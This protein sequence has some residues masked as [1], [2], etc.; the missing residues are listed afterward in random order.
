[1]GKNRESAYKHK[2]DEW[3]QL[4]ESG[5]S[6]TSIAKKEGVF[7]RTV[8]GVLKGVV[9]PRPKQTYAHMVD[10]WVRDYVEKEMNATEIAEA[11]G[12]DAVTVLKYLKSADVEIRN[13]RNRK[14]LF[15]EDIPEWIRRYEAGESLKEIADAYQTFPQTVHKH[16]HEKVDMRHYAETSQVHDIGRPDYFEDIR[17]REQAYWLGIWFGTGFVSKNPDSKECTLVISVKE[18]LTIDR[19]KEVIGYTK[20]VQIVK[21]R[22]VQVARLRIHN[23]QF[24]ESLERHGL[25]AGKI[26]SLAFPLHIKKAL[27]PSFVLGYYEGKGSCYNRKNCIK[28]RE[29]W[30]MWLFIYGT[31]E[32]LGTLKDVFQKELDI[33]VEVKA[34]DS[35]RNPD[36][37]RHEI[38]TSRLPHLERITEWLYANAPV[39]S[40][41]RDIRTQLAIRKEHSRQK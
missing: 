30:Q 33:E 19:F 12:V 6:F 9:E 14:S 22:N 1:M 29:Y 5:E 11:D 35:K 16:I 4:Y 10:K 34:S 20:P 36:A 17:T 39:Y 21:K 28:D 8:Q 24:A 3:K 41:D 13:S 40:E 26:D 18:R 27:L 15:E 23:K 37:I 7:Y 32:F 2:R 25:E 38:R 31:A